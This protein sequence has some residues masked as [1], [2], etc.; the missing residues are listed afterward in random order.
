MIGGK[1]NDTL[2]G[3][4]SRDV[5]IYG[6]GDGKDVIADYIS[7]QDSIKISEGTI[8]KVSLSGSD[9]VLK[10]GSGFLTLKNSKGRKLSKVANYCIIDKI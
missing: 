10:V 9:V 6:S 5:F 4:A 3:G 2:T 1:G 7:G 8:N